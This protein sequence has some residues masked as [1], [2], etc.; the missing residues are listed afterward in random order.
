MPADTTNPEPSASAP[1]ERW[2][3]VVRPEPG[4]REAPFDVRIRRWIKCGLRGFGVRCVEVGITTLPEQLEAARAEVLEL[5]ERVAKLERH[6][7]RKASKR[8]SAASGVG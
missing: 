3:I 7:E 5:R 2:A 1:A 8:M 6:S 4:E